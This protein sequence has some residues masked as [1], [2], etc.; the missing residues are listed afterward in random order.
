MS[1]GSGA[2]VVTAVGAIEG[3]NAPA[4][5]I[6]SF[7][8][9]TVLINVVVP[10]EKALGRV[11]AHRIDRFAGG[12]GETPPVKAKSDDDKKKKK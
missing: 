3:S 2:S 11:I 10:A 9:M 4:T 6:V 5:F 7:A 1:S 8:A 12:S